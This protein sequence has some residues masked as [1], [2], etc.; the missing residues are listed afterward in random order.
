MAKGQENGICLIFKSN[1]AHLAVRR[2][3]RTFSNAS[4][5]RL[6]S[7]FVQAMFTQTLCILTKHVPNENKSAIVI[8][9]IR[10]ECTTH[11][12]WSQLFDTFLQRNIGSC[13]DRELRDG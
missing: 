5:E 7:I 6:K 4:A 9:T 2:A 12:Y 11:R 10:R 3:L 1:I 13:G 8:P